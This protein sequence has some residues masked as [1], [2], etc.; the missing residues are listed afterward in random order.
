MQVQVKITKD[1]NGTKWIRCG[2]CGHKLCRVLNN[3]FYILH[4]IEL[5]CHSCKA[6][7]VAKNV[8]AKEEY[9]YGEES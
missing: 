1:N 7:V 6:S 2:K 5:K 4:N 8:N 9:K 3:D